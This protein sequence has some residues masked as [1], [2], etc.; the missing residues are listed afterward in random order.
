MKRQHVLK[1]G[2]WP[3]EK[4]KKNQNYDQ[5]LCIGKDLFPWKKELILTCLNPPY[6]REQDVGLFF[7]EKKYNK[8]IPASTINYST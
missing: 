4:E 2:A 5:G 8:E 6:S 3:C 1:R 7:K